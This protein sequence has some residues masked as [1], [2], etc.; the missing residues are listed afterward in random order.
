MNIISTEIRTHLCE[1]KHFMGMSNGSE[2]SGH[3]RC[4]FNFYSTNKLLFKWLCYD[5][6]SP[7]LGHCFVSRTDF[8][9]SLHRTHSGDY[10][11]PFLLFL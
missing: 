8:V 6:F 5:A 7:I 2:I 11:M 10:A 4:M 3:T 1:D 9:I